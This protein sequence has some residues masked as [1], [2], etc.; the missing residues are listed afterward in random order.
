MDTVKFP[1]FRIPVEPGV[2][3]SERFPL[4]RDLGDDDSYVPY[5]KYP[6]GSFWEDS[7]DAE[8]PWLIREQL[9]AEVLGPFRRI[10]DLES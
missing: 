1:I 4:D 9:D 5:Y 2:Y 3:E 8:D 6:D 10:R 7:R